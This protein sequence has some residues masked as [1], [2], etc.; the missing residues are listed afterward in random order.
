M[1]PAVNSI[2]RHFYYE[3][4]GVTGLSDTFSGSFSTDYSIGLAPTITFSPLV[5]GTPV[6]TLNGSLANSNRIMINT[7]DALTFNIGNTGN[8]A[9]TAWSLGTTTNIG[10]ITPPTSSGGVIA[11]NGTQ[12]VSMSFSSAAA[13]SVSITATAS[14]S[15]DGASPVSI[16]ALTVDVVSNRPLTASSTVPAA[17]L[18]GGTWYF[19]VSGA[20]NDQL[21]TNPTTTG[22]SVTPVTGVTVNSLAAGTFANGTPT[23]QFSLT[24]P[25]SATT[26]SALSA[27]ALVGNVIKAE[28]LSGENVSASGTIIPGGTIV[29]AA[30]ASVGGAKAS[31]ATFTG[32]VL[33]GE[34]A[35]GANYT[36][37]SSIVTG[38]AGNLGSV[39]TIL[40][41][42]NSSGSQVTVSMTW[43][44]RATDELPATAQEPPMST[45]G[46]WLASDVVQVA[47]IP[48][49]EAYAMQVT[50]DTA[51][52]DNADATY[53]FNAGWMWLGSFDGT[54]W[55]NAVTGLTPAPTPV[56]MARTTASTSRMRPSGR[57][58]RSTGPPA[59]PRWWCL[60]PRHQHRG[61]LGRGEL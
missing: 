24:V 53:N 34:V 45:T 27:G 14:D 35:A 20:G 9:T 18:G 46:R 19:S 41:G 12:P 32:T 16:S 61:G 47:G 3:L 8:L 36:N 10:T 48:D 5:S 49:G 55:Q 39:A 21:Y 28:G 23:Q 43:R 52:L 30:T 58:P 25:Q 40:A 17:M 56:S 51:L 2:T 1:F 22:G 37:L 29:A 7:S 26:L 50:Y 60:G 42:T 59:S 31:Q 33:Y 54:K 6:L 4:N 57:M 13:G 44:T 15:T 38:G 11:I